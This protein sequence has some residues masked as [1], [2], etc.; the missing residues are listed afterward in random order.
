MAILSN[1]SSV[2]EVSTAI[3]LAYSLIR[4]VHERPIITIEKHLNRIK[5]EFEDYAT[6]EGEKDILVGSLIWVV[7]MSLQLKLIPHQKMISRFTYISI[8]IATFSISLLILS[9]FY[10][11][12]VVPQHIMILILSV[13]L[14]PMPLLI[15]ITKLIMQ[16]DIKELYYDLRRADDQF[17]EL[18][19]MN[20]FSSSGPL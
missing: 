9:G 2:F 17:R 12:L 10:P 3:H 6:P 4:E 8:I 14:L 11:N 13:L 15:F 19:D 20:R 1:F 7:D 16:K 18:R 5:K